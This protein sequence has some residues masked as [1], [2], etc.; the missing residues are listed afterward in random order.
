M[1]RF[2]AYLAIAILATGLAAAPRTASA[3]GFHIR[4]S[5][6]QDKAVTAG[7]DSARAYRVHLNSRSTT[8]PLPL[9][10][11]VY[12]PEL[13]YPD[14][15]DFDRISLFEGDSEIRGTAQS[16]DNEA[17][18]QRAVAFTLQLPNL[19]AA[20]P[21]QIAPRT[22]KAK[23]TYKVKDALKASGAAARKKKSAVLLVAGES[24]AAN[25]VAAQP[26]GAVPTAA[27]QPAQDK[28]QR[29]NKILEAHP[30]DLSAP[31]T[32]FVDNEPPAIESAEVVSRLADSV[33][34]RVH[35]SDLDLDEQSLA[36]AD[37]EA[38]V[39][40]FAKA[41][42]QET[43]RSTSIVIGPRLAPDRMSFDIDLAKEGTGRYHF[44]IGHTDTA[45]RLKDIYGNV[46]GE[47]E[48]FVAVPPGPSPPEP[49]KQVPFPPVLKRPP[50]N[51]HEP[52]D[53]D[54]KPQE[55]V[56][57]RVIHLYYFR[58]AGRV[59][60]IIN[61]NVK[62]LNQSGVNYERDLAIKAQ[63]TADQATDRR[64][65]N[66]ALAVQAVQRAR[67]A[68]R[69]LDR[70]QSDLARSQTAAA[71]V[72]SEIDKVE[73]EIKKRPEATA[74][75]SDSPEFKTLTGM[76]AAERAAESQ[77][78]RDMQRL[79]TRINAQQRI[80]DGNGVS[81]AD[82]LKKRDDLVDLRSKI[83]SQ[84]AII[85][86]KPTLAEQRAAA[87]SSQNLQRQIDE[88]N[89]HLQDPD[90]LF[91]QSQAKSEKARLETEIEQLNTVISSDPG[92]TASR[93]KKNQRLARLK[94]QNNILKQQKELEKQR[95]SLV[96]A[97]KL[98]DDIADGP[99]TEDQIGAAEIEK[100]G[101]T[102]K[103]NLLQDQ[104][105]QYP[106]DAEKAAAATEMATLKEQLEDL[107]F[108][109]KTAI[110]EAA[111]D[112]VDLEEQQ[113]HLQQKK[114]NLDN[115]I[116]NAQAR[117]ARSRDEL[118]KAQVEEVNLT[119]DVRRTQASEDRA[120]E[121]QFRLEVN[122][123]EADPNTYAA[124]NMDSSDPVTQCSLSVIGE[125]VIHVR[126]PVRGINKIARMIHQ[127]DTPVGQVKVGIHTV[128]VNGE[129][130]DRMELVY[131]K[132]D[133]H[134][135]HSRFLAHET[136]QLFRKAVM[137]V[138]SEIATAVNQGYIPEDCEELFAEAD[139]LGGSRKRQVQYGAAF[140]GGDFVAEL[141]RMDSELLATDNKLLG[142]NSMDSLSLSGAIYV[143]LVAKNEVRLRI[144]QLFE[145][146][147]M[148]QLPQAEFDYYRAL[149]RI[150]HPDPCVN[151]IIMAKYGHK[152]DAKDG[153]RIFENAA[154][155]YTYRNFRGFFDQFLDG[156]DTLNNAQYATIRLAQAMK[157]QL[158]AELEYKNLVLERSLLARDSSA[159][160]A[161]EEASAAERHHKEVAARRKELNDHFRTLDARIASSTKAIVS[162]LKKDLD[163]GSKKTG[164]P[165]LAR[166]QREFLKQVDSR[167]NTP[168]GAKTVTEVV[169]DFYDPL[170]DTDT[171]DDDLAQQILD[172]VLKV[173]GLE[174]N[175]VLRRFADSRLG[176]DP[177]ELEQFAASYDRAYRT[178]LEGINIPTQ[179][180]LAMEYRIQL[181]RLQ[182]ADD[183]LAEAQKEE[184]EKNRQVF[185]R[186]IIEQ[187]IDESEQKSVELLEAMR[188]HVANVDNFIKRLA[189][190]LEDDIDAQFYKP[191]FAD[192]RRASRYW[193]VNLG[194]IE[195]TTILT[196]NRTFA[197]VVPGATM[198]FN[199]PERQLL[200]TEAVQGAGALA[201]EYGQLLQDP[202]FLAA[203]SGLS[204]PVPTGLT[205]SQSPLQRLQGQSDPNQPRFGAA[206]QALIPDPAI[207]KFET[208][209]GFEIRPVIQPDGHS[210]VY[211]FDY[212]YT[213]NV[214]EPVRADEKHLGRVKR[215]FIHTD[216]QTSS[217]ELREVSRYM[218]ALKASR[219]GKGVPLLEDVP[220]IGG[221]FRPM[222]SQESSLQENIILASSVVYPTLYDLAG[223]RWSPYA[224]EIHSVRLA[225]QKKR[226]KEIGRRYRE[227]IMR[228]ARETVSENIGGNLSLPAELPSEY[229]ERP[230]A[231]EHIPIGPRM[232]GRSNPGTD[233]IPAG[234]GLGRPQPSPDW[235]GPGQ[236]ATPDE[237]EE[238]EAG[239]TYEEASRRSK[240]RQRPAAN[241]ATSAGS[242]WTAPPQ[243]AGRAKR[244]PA[245][246]PAKKPSVKRPSAKIVDRAVATAGYVEAEPAA[247]GRAA[248][249]D[250]PK[251]KA[252]GIAGFFGLGSSAKATKPAGGAAGK[253]QIRRK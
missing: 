107:Q 76:T 174:R 202:T 74:S 119:S 158:V 27:P 34:V 246:P 85:N 92:D 187:S 3:Q 237:P 233:R 8:D 14:Q 38:S 239:P 115:A 170:L 127:I 192:I 229:Q 12:L 110:A 32:V 18:A 252:G 227:T 235:Y 41:G 186:R 251:P 179:R 167:L 20:P 253:S 240:P 21:A 204:G 122:A 63:E 1:R 148:E 117:I 49:G 175:R 66:E 87:I 106:S 201:K 231:P 47:L 217:Y 207:Y 10:V 139:G 173:V 113:E 241:A 91:E 196:N 90:F 213:T 249:G 143:T 44:T 28:L 80:V 86:S 72:Q 138:A 159:R 203:A 30:S 114:Q 206:L 230:P 222:P 37:F 5:D 93:D 126:G 150:R 221:L 135:A 182:A 153:Q 43:S 70:A 171:L 184:K 155:T 42:G 142:I 210:I 84:D 166:M 172:S 23:V 36:E 209:T 81:A 46:A 189:T 165:N 31:F 105:E 244:E 97:K 147:V 136:G 111:V 224:D 102:A 247:P 238:I 29:A 245:A 195:T 156:T 191:A 250:K 121:K 73:A 144:I 55:L 51:V 169:K 22:L 75:N 218:V 89:E 198:E 108:A 243:V 129:H 225:E 226:E 234:P 62:R 35:L 145:S 124:G 168:D 211:G 101:L 88:L 176:Y 52:I 180:D 214:R 65:D 183:E 157:A 125:G 120:R 130:G 11:I 140:F 57:S 94:E 48:V 82:I 134:I 205:A 188:S 163:T 118:D 133:K 71:A 112:T 232:N 15:L 4:P 242:L 152:L 69:E 59:V 83:K 98:A 17:I 99:P 154:R 216:V 193:D 197:K 50:D 146:M 67:A 149:T 13:P 56:E 220:L 194:Q 151:G 26:A 116:Q 53:G 45:K 208:G 132:I 199:L 200:I 7:R 95:I 39:G 248:A 164:D 109:E 78:Q 58:N 19:G 64:R 40:F 215:H 162:A 61:R 161:Y 68:R 137:M 33:T 181:R 24:E 103:A 131:E 185:A 100:Q 190:A 2:E 178:A 25:A 123:G 228:Q 177:F 128:Q 223:L 54:F 141:Q 160:H 6:I 212:M 79:Q 60:E 96:D 9:A 236:E 219:T 104:I 77:R 16:L